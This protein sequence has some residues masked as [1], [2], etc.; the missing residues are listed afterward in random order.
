MKEG[1]ILPSDTLSQII[2][3]T[4]GS[5]KEKK[6]ESALG[7]ESTEIWNEKT[8]KSLYLSRNC[9]NSYTAS[10]YFCL[11]SLICDQDVDLANKRIIMFSYGSGCAATMFSI[12]GK[13][14]YSTIRKTSDFHKR[15]SNR[16]KKSP[17]FYENCLAER[18]ENYHHANFDPSGP[19]E[20]LLPGTFYLTKID[21]KWRRVYSKV[22][23]IKGAIKV[24]NTPMI[25]YSSHRSKLFELS[26]L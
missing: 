10:V 24:V 4:K 1:H 20:E 25:S 7:K 13:E 23:C 21:E 12:R 6:L 2:E 9:G 15:L 22:P 16:I 3:E 18:Q 26:K 17:E 11:M 14:D 8:E 19:I 5:R